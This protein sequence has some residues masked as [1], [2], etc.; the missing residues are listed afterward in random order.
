MK[1]LLSTLLFIICTA[2]ASAKD[3]QYKMRV[4]GMTSPIAALGIEISFKKYEGIRAIYFN[5][6]KGRVIVRTK[7]GTTFTKKE[8]KTIIENAGFTMKSLKSR[9]L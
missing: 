2:S 7:S 3:M 6:H 8:I 1:V 4:D 9:G 5:L